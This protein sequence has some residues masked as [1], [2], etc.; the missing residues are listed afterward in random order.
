MELLLLYL[1]ASPS[2]F[3]KLPNSSLSGEN[4][5]RDNAN[6][7]D[8]TAGGSIWRQKCLGPSGKSDCHTHSSCQFLLFAYFPVSALCAQGTQDFRKRR[9]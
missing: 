1:L 4:L 3:V 7:L 9:W 5:A 8:G 6:V 2:F